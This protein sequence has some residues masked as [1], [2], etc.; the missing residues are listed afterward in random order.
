MREPCYGPP[1]PLALRPEAE[2][3]AICQALADKS[4]ED[5]HQLL[6]GAGAGAL[7]LFGG[8]PVRRS[9]AGEWEESPTVVFAEPAS[10]PVSSHCS[11]TNARRSQARAPSQASVQISRRERARRLLNSLEVTVQAEPELSEVASPAPEPEF[12]TLTGWRNSRRANFYG[13][14]RTAAGRRKQTRNG[15][16]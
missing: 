14:P 8:Y 13:D 3:A 9:A 4:A 11:A 10:Q 12:G 5:T 16:R 7:D 2:R 6:A 1:E 15:G